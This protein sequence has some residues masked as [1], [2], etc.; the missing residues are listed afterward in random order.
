MA[1]TGQVEKEQRD[2]NPQSP[3]FNQVRWVSAGT[4]FTACPLP[5]SFGSDAIEQYVFK[6]NC[7]PGQ[8]G[9]SVRVFMAKDA[10]FS[11]ESKNAANEEAQQAFNAMKQAY[12]NANG[13]CQDAPTGAVIWLPRYDAQGCFTCT[14][15]NQDDPTDVRFSTIG[16]T[17]QYATAFN[18]VGQPCPSCSE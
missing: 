18:S 9:S 10:Y 11:T 16:E 1:N 5:A 3:T 12:A 8:Y 4:D 17:A 7:A 15:L 14:M 2:V 6:D 13:I